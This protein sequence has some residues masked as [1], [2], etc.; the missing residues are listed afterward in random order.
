MLRVHAPI[1]RTLA[2]F[3]GIM[4]FLIVAI[5]YS[6]FSAK[7]LAENPR[8]KL[9]PGAK[10]FAA[11]WEDITKRRAVGFDDHIVVAGES[12]ESIATRISGA[13]SFAEDI[14]PSGGAALDDDPP[15][16][17]VV[18]E[19]LRVPRTERRVV[20]DVKASLRR[21]GTGLGIGISVA[22]LLGLSM[23]VNTP[24]DKTLNGFVSGL[25]K[26]PP[27]AL[28][29][30]I[31]IAMGTGESAKIAIIALGIAPTMILDLYMRVREVPSELI[32]KAYTLGASTL[33]ITFKVILA[34]VWPPF[35]NAVRL[36]LGPAWVYLI[37]SEAIASEAGLGYR[38]FVVQRQL[39]MNV[40]LI[41][42]LLI[43]LL[44]LA[45]DAA[46]RYLI[47]WRYKWA[48]IR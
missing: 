9:M 20:T 34:M 27:L 18:G 30:I 40:I 36:A 23:G 7:R 11:G 8:D 25:A 19:T 41:Y 35:L 24:I 39:G 26:I 21:L 6:H 2:V 33:E 43:M 13:A 5:V 45:M 38:I 28:L 32:T 48:E 29:P 15:R 31:F 10:Q 46:I 4:P 47:T 42:V 17:L 16:A 3:L 1:P 37:A 14:K 22:L 44:G 12:L